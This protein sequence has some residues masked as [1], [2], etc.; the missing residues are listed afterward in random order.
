MHFVD[1]CPLS[2]ITIFYGPYIQMVEIPVC[3][4]SIP[5]FCYAGTCRLLIELA[6][7]YQLAA[8]RDMGL[9]SSNCEV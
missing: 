3:N 4:P 7:S 1:K 2:E 8:Y 9:A 6:P 5:L